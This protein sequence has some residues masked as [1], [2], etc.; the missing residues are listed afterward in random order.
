[1]AVVALKVARVMKLSDRPD[2]WPAHRNLHVLQ[3][4]ANWASDMEAGN[5]RAFL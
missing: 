4:T 1:M 2:P 5:T 3:G